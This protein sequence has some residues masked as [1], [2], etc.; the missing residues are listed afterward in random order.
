MAAVVAR[1]QVCPA[2]QAELFCAPSSML[3]TTAAPVPVHW[4]RAVQKVT[5]LM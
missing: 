4:L 5:N 2:E 3:H 1:V